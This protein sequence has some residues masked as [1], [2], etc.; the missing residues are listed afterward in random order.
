[1]TDLAPRP[2]G[3]WQVGSS[4]RRTS[5]GP[6]TVAHPDPCPDMYGVERKD[7]TLIVRHYRHIDAKEPCCVVTVTP[8]PGESDIEALQRAY[9]PFALCART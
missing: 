4:V 6:W 9:P 1:M 3:G 5:P 8:A 2:R 7:G